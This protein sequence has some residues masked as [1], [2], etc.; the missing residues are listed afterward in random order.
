MKLKEHVETIL[1]YN[2][3]ENLN[4]IIN[5]YFLRLDQV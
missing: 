4:L 2:F 3:F 5:K 1:E